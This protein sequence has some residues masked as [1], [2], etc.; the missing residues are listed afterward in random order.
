MD[1]SYHCFTLKVPA[2]PSFQEN[3]IS[4]KKKT[5]TQLVV[6]YRHFYFGLKKSAGKSNYFRPETKID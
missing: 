1:S 6:N 2:T 5:V 3:N 4:Q